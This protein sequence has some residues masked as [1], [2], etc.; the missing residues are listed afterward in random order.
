M[1]STAPEG[2]AQPEQPLLLLPEQPR[3]L[4]AGEALGQVHGVESAQGCRVGP[5][6]GDLDSPVPP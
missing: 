4:L 5:K 6:V 2:E 3:L 1:S